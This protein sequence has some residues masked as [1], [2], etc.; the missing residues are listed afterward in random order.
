MP[1]VRHARE[2]RWKL[3]KCSRKMRPKRPIQPA[4]SNDAD[5]ASR[6]TPQNKAAP[7]RVLRTAATHSRRVGVVGR[8]A[9]LRKV[10]ASIPGQRRR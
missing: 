7:T 1:T 5:A 4:A 9:G 6:A 10:A 8:A 3:P 2:T